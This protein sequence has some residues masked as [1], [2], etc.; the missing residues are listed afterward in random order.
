MEGSIGPYERTL[1]IRS[2]HVTCCRRLRISVLLRFFQEASIAH[3]EALGMGREKTLDRGLLWI[4]T[5]QHIDIRRMPEY[6]EEITIRSWPG[7]TM[8]VLFPRFYEVICNGDVVITGSAL[9]MLID[10]ESRGFIF[11][12][13]YGIEIPEMNTGHTLP[14]PGTIRERLPEAGDPRIR[15]VPRT[16]TFSMLDING[17]IN[18]CGYFDLTDDLIPLSVHEQ[19]PPASVDAEYLSEI[20][21]GEDFEI[22]WTE[23]NGTWLFEGRSDRPKFRIKLTG[24]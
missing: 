7:E 11:P 3:T 16:A 18:N 8:H 19:S 12:D 17:H 21:A 22:A 24:M 5:K 14:L 10:A 23:E 13:E 4:I 15:S 20:R 1:R 2:Q 9:W 6:D